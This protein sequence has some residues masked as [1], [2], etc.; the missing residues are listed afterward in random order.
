MQEV[1][2]HRGAH[3]LNVSIFML[4]EA[5]KCNAVRVFID[6]F[7]DQRKPTAKKASSYNPIIQNK[8]RWM[9]LVNKMNLA[10]AEDVKNGA[11]NIR[12]RQ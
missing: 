5:P 6:F 9:E 2:V 12:R 8:T 3:E 1:E 7:D 11:D 10:K 4:G